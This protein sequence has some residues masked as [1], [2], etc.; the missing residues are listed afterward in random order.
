ML[1]LPAGITADNLERLADWIE[2]SALVEDDSVSKAQVMEEL[3][4]SGLALPID[5][6]FAEDDDELGLGSDEVAADALERLAEDI[7]DRCSTRFR[8]YGE[9]YPFILKRDTVSRNDVDLD[10]YAFLL[11]ADLG[12]H[13][14]ELKDA[15]IPDTLSGRLMEK[16]VEASAEGLFGKSQR[17]GWPRE[18]DWPTGINDRI[19]RL[20]DKLDI[21]VDSLDG[22]TDSADNDRTL[23]VVGMFRIGDSYEASL[24]ILIQC[25]AG[26]NWKTKL[27][28]PSTNAWHNLLIWNASLIRAVALPWRLGGRRSDWSYARVHAMSNGAM[29]LDRPRL[30]LGSPDRYLDPQVRPEVSKWW[31][32]AVALLP[33][34]RSR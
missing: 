29:V 14:P 23:D 15:L 22:K 33:S 2:A 8:S 16:V 18:P 26:Q 5:E 9:G 7:F 4:S 28:D 1:K 27:G 10:S 12:H 24:S 17:F 34:S 6:A 21:L 3:E 30:L 19:T 13:Y 20:A 25:A 11:V 31:R 32:D